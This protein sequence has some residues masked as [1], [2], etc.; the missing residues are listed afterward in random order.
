[1]KKGSSGKDWQGQVLV[2]DTG[3]L[4]SFQINVIKPSRKGLGPGTWEGLG[5][6]PSRPDQDKKKMLFLTF[7]IIPP[8]I[9][10][11]SPFS[12]STLAMGDDWL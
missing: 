1:M 2:S 8:P 5:N 7:P 6:L 9:A 10:F 11:F 3:G 12:I 4:E